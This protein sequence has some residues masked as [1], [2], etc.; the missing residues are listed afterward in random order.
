M[1][2]LNRT[3]E[4]VDVYF[5]EVPESTTE[6]KRRRKEEEKEMCEVCGNEIFHD[7]YICPKCDSAVCDECIHGR[8]CLGCIETEEV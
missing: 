2:E 7:P 3:D 4:E 8:F 6:A 5:S 1:A